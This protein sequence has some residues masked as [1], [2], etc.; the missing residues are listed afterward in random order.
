MVEKFNQPRQETLVLKHFQSR[1]LSFEEVEIAGNGTERTLEVGQVLAIYTGGGNIG[2]Y[3]EAAVG[4]ANG[5]DTAIAVLTDNVDVPAAGS[6]KSV[7]IQRLGVL[8]RDELIFTGS[9]N[10]AQQQAFI[11][12]LAAAF[13]IAR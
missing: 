9:P 11:D 4:G 7:A 8:D 10:A 6:A 2:T 1:E 13:L 12:S 5:S 3:V